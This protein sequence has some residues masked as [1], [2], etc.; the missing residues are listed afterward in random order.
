MRISSESF[1]RGCAGIDVQ[2]V[3]VSFDLSVFLSVVASQFLEFPYYAICVEGRR[4]FARSTS[5]TNFT[6]VENG[7]DESLALHAMYDTVHR[8]RIK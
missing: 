4:L 7:Y 5:A 6:Y 8:A 1:V 3:S 2:Q